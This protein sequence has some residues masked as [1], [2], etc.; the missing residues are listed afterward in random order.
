MCIL[1]PFVLKRRQ[2]RRELQHLLKQAK[3]IILGIVRRIFGSCPLGSFVDW[4]MDIRGDVLAFG[5]GKIIITLYGYIEFTW[6]LPGR[7]DVT[8]SHGKY[9]NIKPENQH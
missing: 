9:V 6:K 1:K 4:D 5:C 8:A 7:C 2:G 3:K